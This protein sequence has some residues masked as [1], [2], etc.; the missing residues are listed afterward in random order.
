MDSYRR[1]GKIER[2]RSET[3]GGIKWNSITRFWG[4]NWGC[5]LSSRFPF[6]ATKGRLSHPDRCVRFLPISLSLAGEPR[7]R[8]AD[9]YAA[10]RYYIIAFYSNATISLHVYAALRVTPTAQ[11]YNV[12]D[13]RNSRHAAHNAVTCAKLWDIFA[14]LFSASTWARTNNDVLL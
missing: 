9:R 7:I 14:R 13:R 4:G 2:A 3:K 1:Y 11:K 12:T 5:L 10:R 8:D 6:F